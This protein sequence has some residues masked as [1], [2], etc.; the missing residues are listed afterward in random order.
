VTKAKLIETLESAAHAYKRMAETM[1][2]IAYKENCDLMMGRSE[3]AGAIARD[4]EA[5][6]AGKIPEYWG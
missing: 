3:M 4:L 2:E 5:V 6:L 1:E